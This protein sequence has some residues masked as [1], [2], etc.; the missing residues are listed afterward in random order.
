MC[1]LKETENLI[2]SSP[3][4]FGLSIKDEGSLH[5]VASAGTEQGRDCKNKQ[6]KV[7]TRRA[8]RKLGLRSRQFSS[9]QQLGFQIS[10]SGV[11]RTSIIRER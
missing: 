3:S 7:R 10:F 2:H 9:T 1:K 5:W 6:V 4:Q 11:A 8:K